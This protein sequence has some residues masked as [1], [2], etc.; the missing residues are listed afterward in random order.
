MPQTGSFQRR[1]PLSAPPRRASRSRPNSQGLLRQDIAQASDAHRHELSN[2][3]GWVNFLTGSCLY[4]H[5]D[6]AAYSARLQRRPRVAD[7]VK[8][9]LRGI[10]DHGDGQRIIEQPF[11][12]RPA[13]S[14]AA[15][16]GADAEM[17]AIREVL[18]RDS[19]SRTSLDTNTH[20]PRANGGGAQRCFGGR[21]KTTIQHNI[22]AAACRRL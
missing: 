2:A 16:A 12:A 6:L 19:H 5:D 3:V 1:N 21:A 7:V 4:S 10:D 11:I 13:L 17:S 9:K 8:T 22:E 18:E 14:N 20:H 15:E